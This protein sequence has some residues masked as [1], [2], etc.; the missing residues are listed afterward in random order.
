M[1]PTYPRGVNRVCPL[2]GLSGD[3]RSAIDA[4]D[5]A[6]RCHSESAPVPIERQWQAKFCLTASH[7]ACERYQQALARRGTAVAGRAQIGDGLASTRL[8]LAPEPAWRGIA[9]RAHG[10]GRG[11]LVAVG[12]VATAIGAGAFAMATATPDDPLIGAAGTSPSPSAAASPSPTASPRATPVITPAPTE[13]PAPTP[14]PET[15]V[16]T[17][18]PAPPPPQRTYVVQE[19]DSLALIAQQFGTTVE[20]IQ[21]ANGIADPDVLTVGQVLVIP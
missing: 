10:A 17:A 15:P 2:L 9:G 13:T 5:A 21:A 12:A 19:G 6:H 7:P 4:F 11:R 16:P 1:L 3:R 14:P 8:V 20:A 18:T